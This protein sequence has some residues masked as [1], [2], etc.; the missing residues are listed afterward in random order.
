MGIDVGFLAEALV[1]Y[2]RVHVVADADMFKTIVR[3]CGHEVIIEMME[4]GSLTLDFVENVP[5]S[6][7]GL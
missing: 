5:I 6:F 4:M 2:Q 7:I 1:F 3:I